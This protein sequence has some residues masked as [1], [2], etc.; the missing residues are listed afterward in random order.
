MKRLF[1]CLGILL[2]HL[3]FAQTI[4]L[5]SA[6]IEQ[7]EVKLPAYDTTTMYMDFKYLLDNPKYYDRTF[8]LLNNSYS[9]YYH[10]NGRKIYG[11]VRISADNMQDYK[12]GTSAVDVVGWTWFEGRHGFRGHDVDYPIYT[13][14]PINIVKEKRDDASFLRELTNHATKEAKKQSYSIL[15]K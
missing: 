9:L 4:G 12:D 11:G 15:F 6:S 1:V 13:Y 2:A 14:P 7:E 5:R 10:N 8:D 3:S